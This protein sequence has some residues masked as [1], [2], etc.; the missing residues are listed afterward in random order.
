[1]HYWHFIAHATQVLIAPMQQISW[2]LVLLQYQRIWF[3][4]ILVKAVTV[5]TLQV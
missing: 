1:M 2:S 3:N 4:E 5:R